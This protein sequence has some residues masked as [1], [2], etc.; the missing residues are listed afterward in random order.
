MALSTSDL[1]L[2][3]FSQPATD[4]TSK[5]VYRSYDGG[6]HWTLVAWENDSPPY[7]QTGH[8]SSTG[9]FGP[10]DVLA[11][12]PNRAWLAEDRGGLLVTT[13]GG[14]NW[15]SA[16][17]DPNADALGPPY[18]FFVDAD[19]GWVATGDS[20]WRTTDGTRWTEIAP[21]PARPSGK[22]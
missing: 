1:W 19:H 4:M 3:Q 20:L 11:A 10:L 2:V 5:W 12:E 9:D 21:P 15:Q 13:D 8:I 22:S 7:Q 18:V 6:E 17:S 14:L 16:F